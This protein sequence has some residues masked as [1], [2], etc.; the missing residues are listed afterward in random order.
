MDLFDPKP[1]LQKRGGKKHTSKVVP[2]QT[3][4]ES[5]T[6]L[7]SPFRFSKHGESGMDFSDAVPHLA[8]RADDLCMIRS[9]YTE[10][11]NHPQGLRM[12]HTG[13]TFAD[14]PSLGS[15]IVYGLGSE[16]QNLPACVVLRS[17][18]GYANGGTALWD[19]SWL[20]ATFR[21]TEVHSQGE[22]FINLRSKEQLPSG[23]RKNSVEIL[24]RLNQERRELYPRDSRLEARIRNYEL[25]ARMQLE[26][27]AALDLSTESEATK[28]LYGIGEKKTDDYGTRCLMARRLVESGVRFVQVLTPYAS[29]FMPWDQHDNLDGGI[30]DIAKQ[31]DQPS[32][33][34]IADLAQRGLLDETNVM[35]TGEFGRLPISQNKTG[36]DHNRY[37]FSLLLAGGGFR[38][39]TMYGATDEIGYHAVE[40]RVSC[41]DLHATLLHQ[42]GLDHERL[43]FRQN[44]RDETL[45]DV[46]V[47]SASVV[48]GIIES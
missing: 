44:G 23:V 41:A 17:P 27:E 2:F 38:G 9:M 29:G 3:G 35:W 19:S 31:T 45:T 4:S 21:G 7:A 39:G 18:G 36:R 34:L 5:N 32:A 48:D 11:D 43:D 33:A 14:R 46:A 37:A 40:N 25:S 16:N 1:E 47:S 10:N 15:W 42:L 26:A 20:P 28:R 13:K 8:S 6:L 22:P 30:R 12:I 24:A